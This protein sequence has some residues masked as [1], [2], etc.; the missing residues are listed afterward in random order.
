VSHPEH[1]RLAD[2][3]GGW[4][5]GDFSPAVL[6][7]P[8]AEVAVKSYRQGQVE[9]AH[10][11]REATEVTLL[12]SGSARMCGRVVGAGDILVLPP[13]TVTGFE[14]LT[15]CTT[16]VVKSP[17]VMGDKYLVD[18]QDEAAAPRTDLP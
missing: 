2:M 12:V 8:H 3:V 9:P 14:A 16:V 13:F 6:R 5:V 1:Y 4:F 7:S 10:E 17:S 15:D 18:A 11:H